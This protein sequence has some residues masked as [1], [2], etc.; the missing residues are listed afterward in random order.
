MLAYLWPLILVVA[1]NTAYQI[2]AKSVPQDM[3]PFASLTITY[4][5]SA[6]ASLILFFIFGRDTTLLAEYSK[7]N[8]AS[9]VFGIIQLDE[10][11][12]GCGARRPGRADA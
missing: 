2:C 4:V 12:G 7:V 1:A 6:I 3:D 11:D 9:I 8:W 5:V 10:S